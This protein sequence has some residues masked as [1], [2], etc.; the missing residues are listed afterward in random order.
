MIATARGCATSERRSVPTKREPRDET[1]RSK[2]PLCNRQT[3][4]YSR[5]G[6]LS[7]LGSCGGGYDGIR[8]AACIWL[9]RPLFTAD[10]CGACQQLVGGGFAG[11]TGR[12]QSPAPHGSRKQLCTHDRSY[13]TS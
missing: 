13:V 6:R 5:I 2:E 11:K 12:L 7:I 4:Q 10:R 1:K 9:S 3:N 8:L